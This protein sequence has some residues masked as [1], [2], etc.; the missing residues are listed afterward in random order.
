LRY[1]QILDGS[2]D[3]V[4]KGSKAKEL[5]QHQSEEEMNNVVDRMFTGGPAPVCV[6]EADI[7]GSGEI[8]ISDLVFLVD[9][10]FTGEPPPEPC[11]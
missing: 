3:F 9:Y 2:G 7:D 6:E 10:V 4:Y 5:W 1:P 11:P 8:D